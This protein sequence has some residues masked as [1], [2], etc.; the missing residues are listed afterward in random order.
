MIRK[1]ILMLLIA[2]ALENVN[3]QTTIVTSPQLNRKP[4]YFGGGLVLGGGTGSF[5]I[6]LN[7]ELIK[8]Y[9]QYVDLGAA[10]NF[11][12]ASFKYLDNGGNVMSRSNNTQLGLG[13]FA[14]IWP[15][16]KLFVQIQPEYNWTFSRARDFTSTGNSGSA[17]VCAPSVLTGIGYGQRSES[18]FS[19]FSIMF[20][21]INS[22]QSPYRMGQLTAQPIFRAGFGV[23]IRSRR[24]KTD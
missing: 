15:V 18:S 7:P 4:V 1:L 16:Q 5:Q 9:N 8:S 21:L 3:A 6:G 23:P 20:D 13:G 17:S 10:V 22:P 12:Y 24:S 2:I 14:R 11:Y 19:Y